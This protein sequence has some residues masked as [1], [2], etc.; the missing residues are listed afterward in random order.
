MP[1]SNTRPGTAAPGGRRVPLGSVVIPAHDEAAVLPRLLDRLAPAA[2]DGT[3]EVVVVPNGCTDD[4]VDVARGYPA[5][6][7][8][9]LSRGSKIAALNRGDEVATA[10]PRAYIDAD[11]DVTVPALLAVFRALDAPGAPVAARPRSR[12]ATED[13]SASSRAYHRAKRAANDSDE[14]HLWGAG[15]YVLSQEGR[16]RFDHWPDVQGDDYWIDRQFAPTEKSVIDT[17]PVVVR[18]PHTLRDV[19]R[20][21][22]R[23]YRG[24][25]AVE[26]DTALNSATGSGPSTARTLLRLAR[27]VRGPR[28]AA[29]AAVYAAATIA[30]RLSARRA[31][32]PPTWERDATSRRS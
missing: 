28:T 16:S 26:S 10:F 13:A 4:T 8:A 6:T 29:D 27:S 24:N 7:V 19:I 15:C 22:A 11:V 20:T 1:D 32:G 21:G 14:A 31:S 12:Y 30:S 9:E 3:L 18:P 25:A 17:V 23:H 2:A 5:V